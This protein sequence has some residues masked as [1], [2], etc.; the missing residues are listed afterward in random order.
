MIAEECSDDLANIRSGLQEELVLFSCNLPGPNPSALVRFVGMKRWGQAGVPFMDC[1]LC[2]I[3][4]YF[5]G[6]R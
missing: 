4:I 3:T 5:W 2:K 6:A 1:G